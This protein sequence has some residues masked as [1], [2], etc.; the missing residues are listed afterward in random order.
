MATIPRIFNPKFLVHYRSSLNKY[1]LK[2]FDYIKT[3]SEILVAIWQI[4]IKNKKT[5]R[6]QLFCNHLQSANNS[7]KEYEEK[8]GVGFARRL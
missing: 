5:F 6:L 2:L 3:N 7:N 4:K 8:N 1:W